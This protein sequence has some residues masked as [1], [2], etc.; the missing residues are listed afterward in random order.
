MKAA[1]LSNIGRYF[2]RQSHTIGP[3]AVLWRVE[4]RPFA[5]VH[6]ERA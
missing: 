5:S 6:L 2:G 3:N 1:L 4:V